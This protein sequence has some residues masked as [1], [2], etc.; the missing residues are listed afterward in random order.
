MDPIGQR[1]G[2]FEIVR[3]LGAGAMGMVYLA[4]DNVLRREVALKLLTKGSDEIDHELHERFLREARAAARLI[5]PNVVQIFQ[6]GET[7]RHRYIA[8]EYV[9]G[10][11]TRHVARLVAAADDVQATAAAPDRL[12]AAIRADRRQDPPR[13]RGSSSFVA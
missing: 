8:M 5:H 6:I 4:R 1:I 12:W 11:S 7:P 10:A 2:A 13:G 9:E 3:L